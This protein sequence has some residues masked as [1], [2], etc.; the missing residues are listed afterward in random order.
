MAGSGVVA[1]EGAVEVLALMSNAPE[2]LKC[3]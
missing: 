3:C 1:T 2:R